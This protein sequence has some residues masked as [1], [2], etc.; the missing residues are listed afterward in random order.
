MKRNII[1]IDEAKCNGCA[2][3]IPNCPEGALQ[4]IDGKARLVSDLFCDG[5]GACLSECP[6][7]AIQAVE[8]DAEPYDERL[9]MSQI[10]PQGVSTI[11]AHLNHLKIHGES[12]LLKIAIECLQEQNIP[13]PDLSNS[14]QSSGA[15]SN[16]ETF[17]VKQWPIQ[18]KLVNPAAEFFD[19]ADLLISAD[20]VANTCKTFHNKL[21]NGKI[22]IIFC[23]KL[24]LDTDGY[25]DKLAEIF[26]LH[27]IHSVTVA[28][29]LVPCC[30]NTVGITQKA[31]QIAKKPLDITVK[32]IGL[33]GQIE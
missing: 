31:L 3:C 24:D 9:V 25:I 20:C 14:N 6:H 23:P 27:E 11:K 17:S 18:L 19:H 26:R 4:I 15:S 32:I 10:I 13:I 12:K 1:Q 30:G 29:M 22:L 28:R 8:R 16:A 33:D 21:K 2:L 5:L 7:G